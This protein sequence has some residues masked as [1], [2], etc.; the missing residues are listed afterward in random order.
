MIK[1]IVDRIIS[2]NTFIHTHKTRLTTMASPRDEFPT[3][4]PSPARSDSDSSTSS[5]SLTSPCSTSFTYSMLSPSLLPQFSL[6]F[7][8][9]APDF[10]SRLDTSDRV[11]F[12]ELTAIHLDSG[13]EMGRLGR[14]FHVDAR[15]KHV[16]L[17]DQIDQ[18]IMNE[19]HKDLP[20]IRFVVRVDMSIALA[21]DGEASCSKPA[22]VQM[23]ERLQ[24]TEHKRMNDLQMTDSNAAALVAGMFRRHIR[25]GVMI[26][27]GADNQTSG[28]ESDFKKIQL[29]L[30]LLM[31]TRE[32]QAGKIRFE[33]EQNGAD[34]ENGTMVF[35]DVNPVA[36]KVYYETADNV[37]KRLETLA[38]IYKDTIL[39][40]KN[41]KQYA[42]HLRQAAYFEIPSGHKNKD[43]FHIHTSSELVRNKTDIRQTPPTPARL[44]PARRSTPVV[45][46]QLDADSS[47]LVSPP[48]LHHFN[49]ASRNNLFVTNLPPIPV[50]QLA[51]VS[52]LKRNSPDSLDSENAT[53]KMNESS[54][55]KRQH[56]G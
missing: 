1:R 31:Q 12:E 14:L 48:L 55:P 18:F 37:I 51:P 10:S 38:E 56:R 49:R 25:D 45:S 23:T 3:I 15:L 34:E 24:L 20:V 53:E 44:R 9:P 21:L 36:P 43:Y 46:L 28:F 54:P 50:F 7:D 5:T 13:T 16:Y 22:H 52:P 32:Y 30:I 26:I 41:R 19:D 11:L 35:N 33:D 29:A 2:N 6:N 39:S 17:V 42:T 47:N 27:T 4:L 8:S 40:E